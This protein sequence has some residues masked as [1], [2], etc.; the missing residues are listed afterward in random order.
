MKDFSLFKYRRYIWANAWSELHL[1]YAG[2]LFGSLW[3]LFFPLAIVLTYSVVF[4]YVMQR[5]QTGTGLG[6][7]YFLY[8]GSGLFPWLSFSAGLNKASN[9]FLAN[10]RYLTKLAIPE[11]IFVAITIL[12][13]FYTLLIFLLLLIVSG[14]FM[15]HLPGWTLLM[16]PLVS[17]LMLA[18]AYG[19]G[20]IFAA[21][22]VFFMDAKH[23]LEVIL[24][25]WIWTVPIVYFEELLPN[26]LRVLCHFNPLYPFI[27]SYRSVYIEGQI[28]SPVICLGMLFW[29]TAAIALGYA[30]LN[31]VKPEL[32]DCL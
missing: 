4:S 8:L 13:E 16:L 17:I 30:M 1:Q 31:K 28:P 27:V 22:R 32:R 11:D 21:F 5:A 3:N 6:V 26:F 14:L 18:L 29:S 12:R 15:G 9:A 19:L 7:P 20:L 10:A 2:T 24:R 23:I 25:I